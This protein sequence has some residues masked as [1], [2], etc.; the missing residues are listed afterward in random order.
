[1]SEVSFRQKQEIEKNDV[2]INGSNIN[3]GNVCYEGLFTTQRETC[4]LNSEP[5]NGLGG[6]GLAPHSTGQQVI[7]YAG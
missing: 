1:M 4:L 6:S 3:N 5:Q 7:L 2:I